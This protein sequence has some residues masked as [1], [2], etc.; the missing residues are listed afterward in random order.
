MTPVFLVILEVTSGKGIFLVLLHFFFFNLEETFEILLGQKSLQK[1]ACT[2][3]DAQG[4]PRGLG[5][6]MS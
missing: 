2:L 3:Q 1:S 6:K 4:Y 5:K